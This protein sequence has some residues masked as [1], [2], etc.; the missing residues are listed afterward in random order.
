[1]DEIKH[2][3]C[4]APTNIALIKY[5]GKESIELNTPLNSS[6]SLTLSMSPLHTKTT[7]AASKSFPSNRLWLNG[8]EEPWNARVG[9][10]LS[11][12]IKLASN[13]E[14]W[15]EYKFHI[16]SY[17]T[18]PTAA[19]L[20]SSAS[21]YACLVATLS[22]LLSCVESFPNELSTVARQ[23]SGSA[24]RSLYGGLVQWSKG[25]LPDGSDSK[26]HQLVSED[27]WEDLEAI[28]CVANDT[29]KEISSTIGMSQSKKTSK[30][31]SHRALEVVTKALLRNLTEAFEAKDFASFGE[32]VMR[33]SNSFH[34]TCLDT[35]PPIFYLNQV[36]Q[37]IIS[38]V[39]AFNK[40]A[41]RA[42]YTFDAGPNAVIFIEKKNVK[43]FMTLLLNTFSPTSYNFIEGNS[44]LS[45]YS[46]SF[47]GLIIPNGIKKVYHT[48]I[49][50]G[51][52]S[53]TES[54]INL[55]TGLP[56]GKK[57]TKMA[58]LVPLLAV[59]V[60]SSILVRRTL[61]KEF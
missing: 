22:K 34:A 40:D 12:C 23:G 53:T 61:A 50:A 10:V 37:N 47:K 43:E 52:T 48:S 2:A 51:P 13:P 33:D 24:S 9:K 41:V 6:I 44:A 60:V 36:S 46:W 57:N 21:G 30:L 16:V 25:H 38:L 35:Y 49:G 45:D 32:I 39:N 54:L 8:K 31:L 27:H 11:N 42:A 15:I 1:M 29:R 18:F 7:V 19:G 56:I 58:V 59:A 20:A 26:A 5:W 4:R 3:T 17:N 55:K 28:I 14:D